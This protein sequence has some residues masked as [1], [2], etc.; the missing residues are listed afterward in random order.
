VKTHPLWKCLHPPK[1]STLPPVKGLGPVFVGSILGEIGDIRRFPSPKNLRAY[2]RFHLIEGKFPRRMTG[3]FSSWNSYL[4]ETIWLW[5]NEQM[6]KY[7]HP[8]RLFYLWKK[9]KEIRAHPEVKSRVIEDKQGRSRIIY[10]YTLRHFDSRAK[11]WIASQ[12]LNYLWDLWQKL[13]CNENLEL[14]YSNSSWPTYFEQAEKELKN[15]LMK[16][17]K[18]EILKRQRNAPELK[19]RS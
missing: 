17:L 6:P 16:F 7:D 5:A 12:L 14:W 8:W 15:G 18:A 9:A 13:E 19:K 11:R 2:A 4:H 10:D 1:D 3:K